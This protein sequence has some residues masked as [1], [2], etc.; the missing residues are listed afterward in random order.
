MR[1]S[2]RSLALRALVKNLKTE[3]SGTVNCTGQI[4]EIKC[5]DFAGPE[6]ANGANSDHSPVPLLRHCL[7]WKKHHGPQMSSSHGE[8]LALQW[9]C[10]AEPAPP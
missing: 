1:Q 8:L 4:A 5:N 7:G 9:G 10:R 2:L 6:R 3:S